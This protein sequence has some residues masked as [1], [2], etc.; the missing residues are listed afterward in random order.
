MNKPRW[1]RSRAKK[2]IKRV[3]R[4][5]LSS[6]KHKAKKESHTV[7]SKIGDL[8]VYHWLGGDEGNPDDE[9]CVVVAIDGE[10]MTIQPVN[11]ECAFLACQYEV[12]CVG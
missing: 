1:N 10:V 12:S 8:V 6:I 3:I 2:E 4:N 5:N 11:G 9:L 7:T